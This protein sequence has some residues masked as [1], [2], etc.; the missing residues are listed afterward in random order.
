MTTVLFEGS[1]KEALDYLTKNE[2]A[3]PAMRLRIIAEP[4][5]DEED[6]AAGLPDSPNTVRDRAHLFELLDAGLASPTEPVTKEDWAFIRSE[7]QRRYDER[8]KA[9]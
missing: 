4:E 8:N 6:L 1:P 9:K 2:G 5:T 7:V 3:Y